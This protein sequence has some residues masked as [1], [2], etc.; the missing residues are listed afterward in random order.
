MLIHTY[1]L[2]VVQVHWHLGVSAILNIRVLRHSLRKQGTFVHV[3]TLLLV[4]VFLSAG[5]ELNHHC[6]VHL[7]PRG[8]HAYYRIVETA[9]CNHTTRWITLGRLRRVLS[10]LL[11][12]LHL[13]LVVHVAQVLERI[14]IRL[15]TAQCQLCAFVKLVC[16]AFSRNIHHYDV[17]V[18]GVVVIS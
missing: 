18:C 16:E 13:G 4:D 1:V 15:F 2:V 12:Q 9:H 14:I 8:T 17:F 6:A 5:V 7:C 10:H 11:Q 3:G